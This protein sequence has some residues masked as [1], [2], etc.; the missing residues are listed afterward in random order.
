MRIAIFVNHFGDI[1]PQT[2]PGLP[3]S[4][5]PPSF[6]FSLSLIPHGL[7]GGFPISIAIPRTLR[8]RVM[9]MT[10]G[11]TQQ[12]EPCP[13]AS[14]V[15]STTTSPST[16]RCN[17]SHHTPPPLRLLLGWR[18]SSIFIL[19]HLFLSLID[20]TLPIYEM[21]LNYDFQLHRW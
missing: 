3:P 13:C 6:S 1:S 15:A 16:L 12:G 21:T 10:A 18:Q 9:Q 8:Q 17:T 4:T 7:N 14:Q 2:F 19:S 20:I 11:V 5:H